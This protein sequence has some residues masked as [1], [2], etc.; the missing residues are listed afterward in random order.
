[1]LADWL[2]AGADP[3][4]MTTEEVRRQQNLLAVREEQAAARLEKL[5]EER[6]LLFRRGATTRSIALRQCSPAV[7]AAWTPT[8]ARR[9]GS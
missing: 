1:M 3:A 2:A 5:I 4:K 9:S 8:S 7:T 6:D